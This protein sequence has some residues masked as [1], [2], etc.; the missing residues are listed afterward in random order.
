MVS[1]LYYDLISIFKREFYKDLLTL[2]HISGPQIKI[3]KMSFPG[4]EVDD[5]ANFW[6][7]TLEKDGKK[8]KLPGGKLVWEKEIN[9][10]PETVFT[11]DILDKLDVA[12]K[13]EFCFGSTVSADSD[14]NDIKTQE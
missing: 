5:N 8:Y 3:D 7:Y 10:N 12:C 13:K 14:T 9:N 6:G 2:E 11:K 4:G 1:I